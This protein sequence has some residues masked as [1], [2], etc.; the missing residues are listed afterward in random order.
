MAQIAEYFDAVAARWTRAAQT[1]DA[2][3]PILVSELGSLA[4]GTTV[5]DVA[6]GAGEPG[7]S[8]AEAVRAAVPCAANAAAAST[9]AWSIIAGATSTPTSRTPGLAARR[10]LAARWPSTAPPT[11][12]TRSRY[13]A[14]S[15]PLSGRRTRA[16]GVRRTRRGRP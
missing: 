7:L 16:L 13:P 12:R 9:R 1:L 2:L 11:A 5:L 3:T 15:L 6:C 4:A 8:V 14:A 10:H